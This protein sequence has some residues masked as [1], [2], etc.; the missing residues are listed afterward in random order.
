MIDEKLRNLQYLAMGLRIERV[1]TTTYEGL[2]LTAETAGLRDD[3][4]DPLEDLPDQ[5]LKALRKLQGFAGGSDLE[6]F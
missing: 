2:L 4:T 6:T 5:E 3:V 1:E